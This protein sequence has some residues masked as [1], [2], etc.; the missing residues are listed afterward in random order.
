MVNLLFTNNSGI[1]GATGIKYC[2]C[3]LVIKALPGSHQLQ[4]MVNEK[5]GLSP[6]TTPQT[7]KLYV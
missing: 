5:A 4:Y 7:G 6:K 2:P 1:S 3:I